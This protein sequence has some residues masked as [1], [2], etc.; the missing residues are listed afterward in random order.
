MALV[1]CEG[2][3]II[4][5]VPDWDDEPAYQPK[6][7]TQFRYPLYCSRC[8]TNHRVEQGCADDDD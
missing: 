5:R 7:F 4:G 8:H 6:Y 1:L 3:G 2:S